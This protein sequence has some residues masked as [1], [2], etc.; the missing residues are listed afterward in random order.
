LPA[1]KLL[2][3]ACTVTTTT[4]STAVEAG[5]EQIDA[6]HDGK[7]H[8]QADSRLKTLLGSKVAISNLCCMAC[9]TVTDAQV[10]ILP[11]TALAA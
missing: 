10:A 5:Q 4:R 8:Y 1:A 11:K 9:C 2:V 7:R 3:T 6:L